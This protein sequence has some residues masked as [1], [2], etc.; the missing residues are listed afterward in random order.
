[1]R[2]NFSYPSEAEIEEGVRRLAGVIQNHIQK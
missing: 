1:M 2:L